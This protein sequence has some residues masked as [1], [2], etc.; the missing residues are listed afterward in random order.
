MAISRR[1]RSRLG[2]TTIEY[3]LTSLV[4]VVVFAAMYR[5]IGRALVNIFRGGATMIVRQYGHDWGG[6]VK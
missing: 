1:V 6:S 4:L 3:I 2:Q 5:I